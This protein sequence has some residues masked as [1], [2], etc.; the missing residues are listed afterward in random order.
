METGQWGS[1]CIEFYSS[2]ETMNSQKT[3]DQLLIASAQKFPDRMAV[4]ETEGGTM[5]YRELNE[6]SDRLKDKLIQLGVCPGDRVGIYL[7]KSIDTVASIFGILKAGAA[8]V[9]VD[10]GAPAARCAY[11]FSDCTVKVI[12]IEKR[13]VEHLSTELENLNHRPTLIVMDGTGSGEYLKSALDPASRTPSTNPSSFEIS[14]D[15]LAYILYTSGSTGKPKGVM[16]SHRNAISFIDWCSEVFEPSEI[17]RFSSHAPFHFDLSILDIY[18]SLKHGATLVLVEEEV[19]KDPIRLARWISEKRIT[20][21]YSTPSILSFL[22]QY[23]RL[24]QYGYED[25]RSVLFAGEVFPIKH[26]R[27]LKDLLPKPRYFNLYGPTETNVCTYYEVPAT[28]PAEY[29][30][31]FPIGKACSHYENLIKVVDE[32][33]QEVET[34]HEGELI[35]AGPGVMHG[36]WNLPERTANA[37]LIDS[38][39]QR[40][41]KTGDVVVED[42]NGDYLYLSR[43]DRMVKKRGYRV[44]LGEIEAGLYKHPNVEE[45]AVIALSSEENGVQIKAYLSFKGGHNPS[46]IELKRFCTEN[47]P[48]YMVPDFFTFLESLPKTSTNKVDYQKLKTVD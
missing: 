3:L 24:E 1:G 4:E 43:R 34:G 37:F 6:L 38:S 20:V 10:P 30:K 32:Q 13:L 5:T 9:P 47:L 42:E 14:L 39:G 25:L 23:G 18:V 31:P 48:N 46:R 19:G 21:W 7:R 28:I 11:I 26:L 33:G 2:F 17:D 41:Y 16:L 12:L 40:W 45:A 35:A 29:T 8:Y 15:D 27:M 22:A 36:Y 44:E